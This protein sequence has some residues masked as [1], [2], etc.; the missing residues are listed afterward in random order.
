MSRSEQAERLLRRRS[1]LAIRFFS[2]QFALELR[3][4]FQ[5][6]RL[7]QSGPVPALPDGPVVVYSNHPSWWEAV[8]YVYVGSTL[9]PTRIGYGPVAEKQLKRYPFLDRLGIFGIDLESYAGA[10]RFLSVARQLFLE[11]GSVLWITAEGAFT[12]VRARPVVLRPG[13]SH[14]AGVV[15]RVAFVPLA[16][17]Y[18]FWDQ[19]RPE[20][21]LRFGSPVTADGRSRRQ[22]HRRLEAALEGT[23]DAL[24]QEAMSRE[25]SRFRTLMDNRRGITPVYDTVRRVLFWMNK[26]PYNPLHGA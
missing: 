3:R 21:L 25:P 26:T 6:V 2:Y 16:I 9:F 7:S 19:K 13:I 17:E 18:V 12:D 5:S 20:L 10:A 22:L 14:L 1:P 11:P 4:S 8:T 24:A 15:P 23:M